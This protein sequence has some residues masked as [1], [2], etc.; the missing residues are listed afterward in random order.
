MLRSKF[1]GQRWKVLKKP[2]GQKKSRIHLSPKIFGTEVWQL[3]NTIAYCSGIWTD[4]WRYMVVLSP[5]QR[6]IPSTKGRAIRKKT[7]MSLYVCVGQ[8]FDLKHVCLTQKFSRSTNRLASLVLKHAWEWLTVSSIQ[9]GAYER[10]G[11]PVRHWYSKEERY[12][13]KAEMALRDLWNV[14]MCL[15][16]KQNKFFYIFSLF[17]FSFISAFVY[18]GFQIRNHSVNNRLISAERKPVW[19]NP[20]TN[21][22]LV[23]KNDR[24]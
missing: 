24:M 20:N 21:R 22:R 18:I 2:K 3:T 17:Y 16:R 4:Q 10:P 19:F 6:F 9:K 7:K 8:R 13:A 23:D 12:F 15:P 14:R 5:L 1:K 11:A